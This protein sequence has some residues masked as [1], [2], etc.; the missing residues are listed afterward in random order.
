MSELRARRVSVIVPTHNRPKLLSEALATI[1]ALEGPDLS[2]EILVADNGSNPQTRDVADAF[3]ATYIAADHRPGASVARNAAMKTATGEFVA[4][5]DDDDRWLSTHI[6]GHLALLDVRPDIEAV[7]GQVVSV[8]HELRPV[9]K[10][11]PSE[12]PG[13]GNELVRKMLSGY[14][15]QIGATVARTR[16]RELVGEFDERL[17]G[18]EDLDWL[19]RIARR[20]KLGFV[21]NESVLFRGRPYLTYD[22]LQLRRIGYD[23]R[24]FF[25][26]AIPEWRIWRSPRAFM[27]AYNGTL[28]HYYRYFVDAAVSR[29]ACGD[30]AGALRAI[31]YAFRVFP[32][33]A[34]YHL[35][36]PRRL[37]GAFL[38]M[39][40]QRLRLT[41]NSSP[42]IALVC[43]MVDKI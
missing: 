15:P 20:H 3:G 25:R 30:R 26:H 29:A 33:R 28:W 11:W 22:D 9:G 10:P 18:G 1:R 13:E 35:I 42:V 12:P 8:D 5:L 39:F 24:V 17:I 32:F 4:F 14:F 27:R 16:I 43:T 36:A 41:G 7:I 34:T 19:L 21:L 2:F 6:R 31:W 37:R 23:R 40:S 38:A